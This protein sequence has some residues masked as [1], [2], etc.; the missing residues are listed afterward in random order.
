[1]FSNSA[2]YAVRTVL[3]IASYPPTYKCT[4]SEISTSL[5]IPKPYLG[6]ILQ[7]LSKNDIITST[8]GRGG[9]FYL[10]KSNLKR[11][12]N[13]IILCIDGSSVF[14]KCILGLPHCSD[15]RPCHFHD[16][17]KQFKANLEKKIM[18]SSINDLIKQ[19]NIPMQNP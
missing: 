15:A 12:V 3:F 17:Y 8:K 16:D 5:S 4:A 19:G 13:D 2:K 7:Q 18:H 6:K 11:S 10:T 14:K 9:G 1:M